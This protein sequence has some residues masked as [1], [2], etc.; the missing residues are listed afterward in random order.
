MF[1]IH[2]T[3]K[4]SFIYFILSM[5]ITYTIIEYSILYT[6]CGLLISPTCKIVELPGSQPGP[7]QVPKRDKHT[8]P[9]AYKL[10]L[11]RI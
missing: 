9:S 6:K 11:N 7:C 3:Y 4:L 10:G 8:L 5:N 2:S 1:I